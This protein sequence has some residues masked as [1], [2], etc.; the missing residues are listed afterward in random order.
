MIPIHPDYPSLVHRKPVEKLTPVSRPL[1]TSGKILD[2]LKR[3][4]HLTIPELAGVTGVTERS[5][6]RNI[7]KLQDQGL[8]RRIGPAKG[9]HWR[10]IE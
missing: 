10:V 1:K 4:E 9:G 8:L 7:R 6:E 2:I 5:I 3:N